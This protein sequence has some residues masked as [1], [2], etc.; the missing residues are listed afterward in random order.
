MT[1]RASGR[2]LPSLEPS[3]DHEDMP[4]GELGVRAVVKH[5]RKPIGKGDGFEPQRIRHAELGLEWVVEDA[6][7]SW[8]HPDDPLAADGQPVLRS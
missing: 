1:D 6:I 2:Y 5:G 4:V 3:F 7:E 8:E